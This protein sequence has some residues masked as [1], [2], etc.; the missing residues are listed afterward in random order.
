MIVKEGPR[1][2][3][4]G[5]VPAWLSEGARS[6]EDKWS[7]FRGAVFNELWPHLGEGTVDVRSGYSAGTGG[8]DGLVAYSPAL[9]VFTIGLGIGEEKM[10]NATFVSGWDSCSLSPHPPLPGAPSYN[11]GLINRRA[12]VVCKQ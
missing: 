7:V 6:S 9:R 3:D 11:R 5:F 1:A 4:R 2:S 10:L 8:G 12:R